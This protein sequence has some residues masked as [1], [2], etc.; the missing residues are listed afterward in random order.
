MHLITALHRVYAEAAKPFRQRI[1]TNIYRSHY[2]EAMVGVAL[3]RYGWS[4]MTPWDSW[5]LQHESGCR[6]DVKQAAAAQ[7]WGSHQEEQDVRFDVAARDW[8]WDPA[9]GEWVPA[10]G[11]VAHVYVFGWH[12]APEDRADHRDPTSW[13]WFVIPVARLRRKQKSIGLGPIRRMASPC[14]FDDLPDT[15]EAVRRT[16]MGAREPADGSG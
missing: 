12:G 6:L 2:V 1:M 9:S 14:T 13:E 3:D 7:S 5:D 10:T 4:R 11:R 16:A 8:Y 15:V